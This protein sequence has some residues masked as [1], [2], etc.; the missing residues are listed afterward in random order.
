MSEERELSMP[1]QPVSAAKAVADRLIAAIAVG[2]YSAGERLP[3]ERDLADMLAVSRVTVRAALAD[4]R[5]A[6]YVEIRRGRTGG[7]FVRQDWGERTAGAVRDLL[8]KDWDQLEELFD[9]RRL[10]ESLIA[11]TAAERH[12]LEDDAAILGALRRYEEA[13][14]GASARSADVELHR[15]IAAAAHNPSL[16]DLSRQL[17]AQVS[18]GITHEPFT[19]ALRDMA[20][21][22]HRALVEAITKSDPDKA[23]AIAGEH[24]RITEHALR[25][26]VDRA[27]E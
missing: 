3:A 4:L 27:G 26:A 23:A 10:I 21:P 6:G 9:L 12:T 11:R 14:D 18:L 19:P 1:V 24:F 17:L 22:Q 7:S 13:T 8:G 16:A 20:L 25:H 2:D 15:S 5:E